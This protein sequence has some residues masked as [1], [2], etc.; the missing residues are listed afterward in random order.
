[1]RRRSTSVNRAGFTLLEA[2]IA[3]TILAVSVGTLFTSFSMT[4]N[5]TQIA[6]RDMEVAS[7]ARSLLA[8][9]GSDIPLRSGRLSG[10]TNDLSWVVDIAPYRG[11]GEASTLSL[12]AFEISLRIQS[13]NNKAEALALKTLRLAPRP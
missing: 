5:G 12:T 2:L 9:I 3:L 10:D 8:R 11:Q 4:A 6:H 1:M 13:V 7:L